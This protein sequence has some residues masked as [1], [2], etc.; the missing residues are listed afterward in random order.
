PFKMRL[1][2]ANG[3]PV[4]GKTIYIVKSAV[5]N[6]GEPVVIDALHKLYGALETPKQKPE[7]TRVLKT[8]EDGVFI[9]YPG[10]TAAILLEEYNVEYTVT[11]LAEC[12]SEDTDWFCDKPEVTK[13]LPANGT[14]YEITNNWRWK[15]LNITKTVTDLGLS[16]AS[17]TEFTFKIYAADSDGNKVGEP[18]TDFKWQLLDSASA[19]ADPDAWQDPASDG[20]ITAACAGKVI[21]VTRFK[22]GTGLVV[23]EVL[24]GEVADQYAASETSVSYKIPKNA[25]YGNV[26]F[27]NRWLYRDLEVNKTVVTA[28]YDA[29]YEE[30]E[31]TFVLETAPEGSTQF[32][33]AA[34]KEYTL[35]YVG[36]QEEPAEGETGATVP[37]EP[38]VLRTDANGQ[39][40]L[41]HNEKAVFAALEKVGASWRVKELVDEDY[42]PLVP[43]ELDDEGK[44]TEWIDG[45]MGAQNS[46][47]FVNG[48]SG[49]LILKKAWIG[50]DDDAKA[51]IE[52]PS[53]AGSDFS[54]WSW[55]AYFNL[56]FG[57]IPVEVLAASNDGTN[58][59][60]TSR[61]YFVKDEDGNRVEK[62]LYNIPTEVYLPSTD[63]YVIFK[64]H[65]EAEGC[66][67]YDFNDL[68]YTF[69]EPN[70][71]YT[72]QIYQGDLAGAII[73]VNMNLVTYDPDDPYGY[74]NP[75]FVTQGTVSDDPVVV[76][77][78]HVSIFKNVVTKRIKGASVAPGSKLVWRVERFTDGS[79][80]PAEGVTY[81]INSQDRQLT[82]YGSVG[83]PV[84]YSYSQ[85]GYSVAQESSKTGADGKIVIV[86]KEWFHDNYEVVIPGTYNNMPS[87]LTSL[88]FVMFSEKV[89]VNLNDEDAKE[90]DFRVVELLDESDEAWGYLDSYMTSPF[91]FNGYTGS[92]YYGNNPNSMAFNDMGSPYANYE[93]A[94]GFVNTNSY[95]Y[96][97]IEKVVDEPTSQVFSF[98]LQQYMDVMDDASL[99]AA[100]GLSYVVYDTESD[101]QIREGK[102]TGNGKFTLQGGQY[103]LI[104]VP[105]RSRWKVTEE[106]CPSYHI[107][108][109]KV[110]GTMLE[111]FG[112]SAEISFVGSPDELLN[113]NIIRGGTDFQFG[114]ANLA[115]RL[116]MGT[117][118]GGSYGGSTYDIRH[119]YFGKTSDYP[120]KV[121][122]VYEVMDTKGMGTIRAYGEPDS[123]GG[124]NVFILS[125]DLMYL[126]PASGFTFGN[127]YNLQTV[128]F[129]NV[130]ASKARDMSK[131]FSWC[132]NLVS[133]TG[134][135]DWDTS[136]VTNMAEMFVHDGR[137]EH[138]EVSNWNTSNVTTMRYMFSM[139]DPYG[140]NSYNNH[141]LRTLDLS[142][143]DTSK[144]TDMSHMFWGLNA[145][146]TLNLSGEKWNT[147]NVRDMSYMFAYCDSVVELD[148]ADWDT[149][150]VETMSGMFEASYGQ[151]WNSQTQSYEYYTQNLTDLDLSGWVVSKVKY[152]DNMFS[153]RTGLTELNIG[154]WDVSNVED[155]RYMFQSCTGLTSMDLSGWDV[156]KVKC[157]YEMFN[158]CTGL[159][160]LDLSG[161][162]L[163][164]LYNGSGSYSSTDEFG[165]YHY[166]DSYN[167]PA[168]LFSGCSSLKNLDISEWKMTG[169]TNLNGLF[170]GCTSLEEADLSGWDVSSVTGMERMFYNCSSLAQI[171]LDGWNPT[172]LSNADSMF[173]GC[174]SLTSLDTAGWTLPNLYDAENMFY[175]CSGLTVLDLS[176]ANPTNLYYMSSMFNSCSNLE[177]LKIPKLMPAQNS[178]SSN[179]F[180]NDSKLATII[181]NGNW[182]SRFYST[183]YTEFAGCSGLAPYGWTSSKNTSYYAKPIANGGYFTPEN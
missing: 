72:R 162:D 82:D 127:M 34:N 137:L 68:E 21:R 99:E 1:T 171:D 154:G 167:G 116:N 159:V 161:W 65:S 61:Y 153:R 102:T 10:E 136:N 146:E 88:A 28:N 157:I 54:G 38:V 13:V 76:V 4:A 119:I 67:W 6:G 56:D 8:D 9:I 130:D 43:A 110:N 63:S 32:V 86:P 70:A 39:F 12:Y 106:D 26:G 107:E 75:G 35:V 112:N 74:N 17:D 141:N 11:E 27:T 77:E 41:R 180:N 121:S 64:L 160:S 169:I 176:A 133:V 113:S 58:V 139:L 73:A 44:Y 134:T 83:G 25:T 145:L 85:Y 155:M 129:K 178:R 15:D 150:N 84:M 183:N 69:T 42:S 101:E 148:V 36:P 140:S 172:A 170:S 22:A 120:D 163:R 152:M 147:S 30:K 47:S 142:K 66:G 175:G 20:S 151:Y 166:Y 90:G 89:Y 128:D 55:G 103:A 143:W 98:I 50:D 122:S 33:P 18:I 45:V 114:I 62:E 105:G 71:S 49:I 53:I 94:T 168:Y 57:G 108:G 117:S 23:E 48:D 40:K 181:C 51:F 92:D 5:T 118:Y 97:R 179:I 149:S 173:Y 14:I 182:S 123:D 37:A 144:V 80:V 156:S 87:T 138:I 78:N 115:G 164:G 24:S 31:F 7:G 111:D 96:I 125:D 2:D 135:S 104:K 59:Y 93:R 29:D 165:N 81:S 19:E 124:Y 60:T 132:N 131:M 46:A 91:Y 177:T 158:G 100:G 109:I 16:D 79:W 95:Q 174:A 3:A 126:N 52:D